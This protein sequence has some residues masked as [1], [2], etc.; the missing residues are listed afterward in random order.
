MVI[1]TP[2]LAISII[3]SLGMAIL[4][5]EKKEDFPINGI[6]KRLSSIIEML[7]G[8]QW[9]MMLHCTVCTSFWT[10]LIVE[11]C[12]Y[13][14]TGKTYFLWPLTGFAT[15]GIMYLII[16]VLNILDRRDK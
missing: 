5:V 13:F 7:F 16:D 6:H 1:E 8:M 3:S 10:S 4:L 14:I 2:I 11:V 15:A 12:L 9:S